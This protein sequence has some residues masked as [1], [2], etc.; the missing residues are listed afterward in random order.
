M[1]SGMEAR[2]PLLDLEHT[3]FD[4]VRSY[5]Q[6]EETRQGEETHL[7]YEADSDSAS[8]ADAGLVHHKRVKCSSPIADG[9]A[10]TIASSVAS[11]RSEFETTE[12]SADDL[13]DNLDDS[14]NSE[15]KRRRKVGWTSTE[16]LAILA[17]VRRLGTQ[18]PR[19][20]AQLP[21]RTPDAVR[22]RW[23]RL[24]K[25]HSLGDT[26]E[27]KSALDSLLLACGI[28]K[29]W[30]P[31]PDLRVSQFAEN[32]C[33]KGSDHGRAMW[34]AYEDALI[35][36]GVRRFGCKW[37]Q[38]AGLLPGRSDS[39]VRN[40]WMRLQKEH[41]AVRSSDESTSPVITPPLHPLT[42][43]PP[44]VIPLAPL[45]PVHVPVAPAATI[46]AKPSAAAATFYPGESLSVA[47]QPVVLSAAAV[48]V[49]SVAAA[50]VALPSK[51]ETSRPAPL[52]TLKRSASALNASR[53]SDDMPLG[54][55][56]PMLG[57]DLHLFV[58]AVNGAI[59]ENGQM[60]AGD[61]DISFEVC[62]APN[63][64]S[65][66][67]K[68]ISGKSI[69]RRWSEGDTPTDATEGEKAHADGGLELSAAAAVTPPCLLVLSSI[70]TGFAALSIGAS[71]TQAVLAMN[72]RG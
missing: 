38:I 66:S 2:A 35:E 64:R 21:G 57:F 27:G 20:A 60:T 26:Q 11:P 47:A 63:L 49:T 32:A 24:Q 52:Q 22:N 46:A 53:A 62:E 34:T 55:G 18:W 13:A 28:D 54:F 23:H 50:P 19:I 70:L 15:A 5:L 59:D 42:S 48:P 17:T 3:D 40:R 4:W 9:T 41:A 25:T 6:R 43:A 56:S 65:S 51:P 33:I 36:E 30:E 37:R 7:F 14:S 44:M 29:D 67:S 69:I 12:V 16:D 8:T 1:P 10:Y 71:L 68:S 58:D 39:S 31:P 61:D 72:V 45:K